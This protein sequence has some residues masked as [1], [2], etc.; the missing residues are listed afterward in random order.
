M[1]VGS[2][3]ASRSGSGIFAKVSGTRKVDN[4]S[5]GATTATAAPTTLFLGTNAADPAFLPSRVS[6]KWQR[7]SADA[8]RW[9]PSTNM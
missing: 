6:L 7:E 8:F 2:A 5:S 9:S 4:L 1:M 3:G